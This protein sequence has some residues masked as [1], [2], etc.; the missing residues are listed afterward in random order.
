MDLEDHSKRNNLRIN[1]IK[2]QTEETFE[3]YMNKVH[4]V[5]KNNLEIDPNDIVIKRAHQRGLNTGSIPRVNAVQF[6]S[7]NDK[8]RIIE[9]DRK[10][11]GTAM[12]MSE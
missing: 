4:E 1:G 8:P 3:G 10:L 7:F 11:K 12:S 6:N 5:L 2:K 9:N